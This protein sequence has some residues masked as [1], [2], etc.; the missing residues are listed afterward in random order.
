MSPKC[1]KKHLKVQKS[2]NLFSC[3]YCD[4]NT[5]QKAHLNKHL[6]TI[7]HLEK[8]S[9]S[10]TDLSP[11]C[12][13]TPKTKY[14]CLN[15][16]KEYKSRN[17]LWVHNKKCVYVANGEKGEKQEIYFNLVDELIKSKDETIKSKDETIEAYKNGVG[18]HNMINSNNVNNI[19]INVF[20]NEHCK[21]AKTLQDFIS[22]I[23]FKL[24]DV[25]SNNNYTIKDGLTNV[26]IKNLEDLPTTERPIHCIDEKRTNFVIK[27][28]DAG[29]IKDNG[30]GKGA[31]YSEVEKLRMNAYVELNDEID[32]KYPEPKT[33]Y[34]FDIKSSITES[35]ISP[36]EAE[37][38]KRN[39]AVIKEIAKVV[40]IKNAMNE[41]NNIE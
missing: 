40:N 6:Q 3:N 22:Q 11:K 37:I 8:A 39:C 33:D 31:I 17:G 25:L 28:K 1:K 5:S 18:N 16:D 41:F 13:K 15:C 4:Y 34:A 14:I 29:W 20:L 19:S 12:Q 23:T 24:E 2:A 27:D 21:D 38:D 10:V 30:G 26:V 35:I 32:E 7:K 36:N 9:P